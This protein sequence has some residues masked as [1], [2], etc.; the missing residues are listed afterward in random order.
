[1]GLGAD[2]PVRFVLLDEFIGKFGDLSA[3]ALGLEH[4]SHL[5]FT[6]LYERMN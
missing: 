6:V 3:E 5:W 2:L 4:N 1:M